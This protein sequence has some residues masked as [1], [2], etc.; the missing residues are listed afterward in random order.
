MISRY[1]WAQYIDPSL[2]RAAL[3]GLAL[4]KRRSGTTTLHTSCADRHFDICSLGNHID[5]AIQRATDEINMLVNRPIYPTQRSVSNKLV[6][7]NGVYALSH[8]LPEYILSVG[9]LTSTSL[10]TQP[11]NVTSEIGTTTAVWTITSHHVPPN[12]RQQLPDDSFQGYY[13]LRFG[14][15]SRVTETQRIRPFGVTVQSTGTTHTITVSVLNALLIKESITV[16]SDCCDSSLP[17]SNCFATSLELIWHK[18]DKLNP[19]A[20][21]DET[22]DCEPV[23]AIDPNTGEIVIPVMARCNAV[24]TY[25]T[26]GI[27]KNRLKVIPYNIYFDTV[28]G[29]YQ[30]TQILQ[31]LDDKRAQV[32]LVVGENIGV[33]GDVDPLLSRATALL[34]THYMATAEHVVISLCGDN[35]GFQSLKR[36]L[37]MPNNRDRVIMNMST[38]R[39][40]E[41]PNRLASGK[42]LFHRMKDHAYG[43]TIAGDM[44]Y[45]LFT[46][47]KYNWKVKNI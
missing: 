45:E 26:Q 42:E 39:Y 1:E 35:C 29:T 11:I 27:T 9:K 28:S 19:I 38:E 22:P 16:N 24:V 13:T 40:D 4:N 43:D 21:L 17:N 33:T 2:P 44:F 32:E 8:E 14:A 30:Q 5:N 23:D 6:W 47:L 37:D 20:V 34:A 36:Y 15:E 18:V 25:S 46:K 10:G 3:L 7:R 12:M 41:S 31:Q